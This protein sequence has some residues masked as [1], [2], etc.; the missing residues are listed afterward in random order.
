MKHIHLEQCHSTQDSLI[1]LNLETFERYLISTDEQN[2][3]RGRRDNYWES[4][5]H[6][7]CFSMTLLPHQELTLSSA[8]LSIIVAN[9][10]GLFV[11]WPND[12]INSNGKKCGGILIQKVHNFLIVGIGLNLYP[13]KLQNY[14][15][16]SGPIFETPKVF[17]YSEE[18]HKLATYIHNKRLRNVHNQWENRCVHLNKKV[19]IVEDGSSIQGRFI[20]IGKFG[21]ALIETP[22]E[23]LHIYNGSLRF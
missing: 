4:N 6:S 17:S 14:A 21:E 16:E 18:S 15:I 3:G 10:Y 7:L 23:T 5:E 19:S 1:E 9:Y 20:G 11:K 12:L 13:S 8:E 2:A 22:K